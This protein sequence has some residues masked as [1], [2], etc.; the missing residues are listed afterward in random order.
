MIRYGLG[1]YSNALRKQLTH[2][3]AKGSLPSH[4]SNQVRQLVTHVPKGAASRIARHCHHLKGR[5]SIRVNKSVMLKRIDKYSKKSSGTSQF[6]SKQFQGIVKSL[7]VDAE[8]HW[9]RP[10]VSAFHTKTGRDHSL[11]SS[12]NQ[13]PKQYWKSILNPPKGSV[14]V[15]LDYQQ[16]EPMIAAYMAGC[17]A[18]IRWYE[19]GDI[20]KLLALR[21]QRQLNREQCKK[22]LIG[23]LYG[24]GIRTLA[25]QLKVSVNQVRSWLAGLSKVIQPIESFLNHSA[26]D[27]RK[28]EVAQSLDWQH[29]ISDLDGDLSL[30]NWRIQATGADI[31]R[32]ACIK[33]DEANIPLLLTNHD[34]FLVRLEQEQFKDQLDRAVQALTD[35]AVDVLNGFSLKVAIE[36]QVPSQDK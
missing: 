31:M 34:S 32:R 14:Y 3:L 27:I 20:Y 16:Q 10:Y 35:A 11:G 30:R 29:T 1:K 26:S 8:G 19:Q 6:V 18:L 25:E 17:Q 28:K 15:L 23:H 13:V 4:L 33:L 24:I 7:T 2:Y 12:L 5:E 21:I 22:L 36:I 9:H